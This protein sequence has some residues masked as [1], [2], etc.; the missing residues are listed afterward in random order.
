V[1]FDLKFRVPR[2]S[3][4]LTAKVN[5]SPA[6]VSAQP[7]SWAA[8]RR[9][10]NP[11]DRVTIQISMPFHLA[12]IDK[13]HPNRVALM[14][15]SVVLVRRAAPLQVPKNENLSKWLRR[16][17]KH[18]ELHAAGRSTETFVPFYQLEREAPYIM[19]FD[20]EG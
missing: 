15:G 10:W 19:Y 9:T 2:W 20:L 6:P 14:Y 17:G 18:L 16:E 7:G 12:P 1:A 13:Q 11:G 4:G 5:D 8:I 3:G